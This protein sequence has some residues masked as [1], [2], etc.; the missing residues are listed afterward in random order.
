[1]LLWF[2]R[3]NDLGDHSHGCGILGGC[4]ILDFLHRAKCYCSIVCHLRE[5]CCSV[6]LAS[7]SRLCGFCCTRRR[8]EARSGWRSSSFPRRSPYSLDSVGSSEASCNMA[9]LRKAGEIFFGVIPDVQSSK[10]AISLVWRHHVHMV[11]LADQLARRERGH[12][13]GVVHSTGG[14][15]GLQRDNT[16]VISIFATHPRCF[17]C[18]G[19]T[20]GACGFLPPRLVFYVAILAV[21]C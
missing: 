21:A 20:L 9:L 6:A 11:Q 15:E 18:H 1:M 5:L 7:T 4:K 16:L 13:A 3:C 17:L 12:G 10:E 2:G 8:N 19:D 14:L